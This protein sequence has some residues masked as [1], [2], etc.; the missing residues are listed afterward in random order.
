MLNEE[1]SEDV[2]DLNRCHFWRSNPIRNPDV[3]IWAPL[4]S[5]GAPQLCDATRCLLVPT[6]NP[7]SGR[8]RGHHDITLWPLSLPN[9]MTSIYLE[10]NL[11]G[12][13][14]KQLETVWRAYPTP[15]CLLSSV[16]R[17]VAVPFL[18]SLMNWIRSFLRQTALQRSLQPLVGKQQQ[19]QIHNNNNKTNYHSLNPAL[20]QASRP[21][22]YRIN[23]SS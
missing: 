13:M 1:K 12:E 22:L 5:W 23:T 7:E 19:Q 2:S 21:G 4:R 10:G 17:F 15:F 20:C 6:G 11:T 16:P 18:R 9:D 14:E 3:R 8:V